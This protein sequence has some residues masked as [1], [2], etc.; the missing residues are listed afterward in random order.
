VVVHPPAPKENKE[1][2]PEEAPAPKPAPG[3]PGSAQAKVVIEVPA[4]ARLYFDDTPIGGQGKTERTFV[5]P[6]LEQGKDYY[7]VVKAEVVRDGQTVSESHR[8]IVRAGT[9]A[10]ASLLKPA[11]AA[12]GK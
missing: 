8:L 9:E 6:P 3:T 12:S 10:R 11:L 4:E 5:T 7:Y 2:K 1:K